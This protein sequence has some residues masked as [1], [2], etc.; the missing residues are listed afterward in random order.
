MI[1]KKRSDRVSGK[2]RSRSDVE[3]WVDSHLDAEGEW[4]SK[5]SGLTTDSPDDA[6][7][8]ADGKYLIVPSKVVRTMAGEFTR[9]NQLLYLMNRYPL[10]V[11]RAMVLGL[12][13]AYLV[14]NVLGNTLMYLVHSGKPSDLREL[15]GAFKQFVKPSQGEQ[16]DRLLQEHFAGQT[17]G[18]FVATQ[19]PQFRATGRA[20][21]AAAATVRA[22]PSLDRRW[23]QAL[24]RAKVKAELRKHPALKAQAKKMGQETSYFEKIAPV[25]DENPDIVTPGV[26]PGR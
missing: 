20:R 10:K 1:R 3:E 21:K 26:R 7:R 24:R 11:W 18:G 9:Q 14:N 17:H 4:K 13:P 22:I 5:D 12:R 8:D 19:M 15:T 2:D 25:L 16:I 23:E 6:V